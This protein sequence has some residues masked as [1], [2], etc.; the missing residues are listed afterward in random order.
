MS[1]GFLLDTSV[2]SL[3]AP[4][5]L[6]PSP[7]LATWLRKH[8]DVLYLSAVSVV[9]IEQG[10]AK[11]RRAG[12]IER[13]D[14]LTH[15][16]EALLG[17]AADRVLPIDNQVARIAGALSDRTIACGR[18]PGFADVAIAATTIAH[19]LILVTCNGCYFAPLGVDLI[20]PVENLP[21]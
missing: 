5:R 12:G 18:H 6:E 20:N 4:D 1:T 7:A 14:R 11:L 13:A 8:I 16:L 10:I 17:N 19:K 21:D 9:E 2:L 15:W 3:L